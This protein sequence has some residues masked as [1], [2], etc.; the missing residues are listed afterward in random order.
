MPSGHLMPTSD[1][2]L[3]RPICPVEP[4]MKFHKYSNILFFYAPISLTFTS[5]STSTSTP[6]SQCL[7][8]FS[9]LYRVDVDAAR[10]VYLLACHNE[11]VI[12][13]NNNANGYGYGSGKWL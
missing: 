3:I 9:G 8:F 11:Y 6:I 4:L 12:N 13:R 1:L 10:E 2:S 5:T 7:Y